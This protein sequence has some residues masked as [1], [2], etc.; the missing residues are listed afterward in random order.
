MLLAVVSVMSNLFFFWG[1]RCTTSVGKKHGRL[2]R[3]EK[4][5]VVRTSAGELHFLAQKPK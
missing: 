2:K 5:H 4:S 1:G 3:L